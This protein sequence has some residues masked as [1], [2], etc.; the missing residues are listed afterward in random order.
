MVNT[1]ILLASLMHV[2]LQ[3]SN[4]TTAHSQCAYAHAG[5]MRQLTTFRLAKTT[6][7][8]PQN[9][10]DTT[11]KVFRQL[12]Q[13][14]FPVNPSDDNIKLATN[15]WSSRKATVVTSTQI[16]QNGRARCTCT[17]LAGLRNPHCTNQGA[18]NQPIRIFL[19]NNSLPAQ[20]FHCAQLLVTPTMT[21]SSQSCDV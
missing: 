15:H 19:L 8:Q 18:P 21:K 1:L 13:N 7:C 16:G 12:E 17:H 4:T 3:L 14:N 9:M 6:F 2:L 20:L 11:Q 5:R 10:A